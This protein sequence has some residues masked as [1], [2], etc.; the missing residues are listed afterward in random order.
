MPPAL[1]SMLQAPRTMLS[2]YLKI[3][4]RNLLRQKGFAFINITGLSIG[5]GCCMLIL[6]YTKDEVSYDAF[7]EKKDQLYRVTCRIQGKE[8]RNELF[9]IAAMIEGPSFKADIP[10]VESYTRVQER[11]FV[12]RKGKESFNE[13]ASWVDANFFQVFSFPLV[14]GDP[15]SVLKDIH[16]VVLTEEMAEKYFGTTRAIGKTL[17]LE[18]N[19]QFETFVV[20]GVA[21]RSPQNSSL[22]FGILLPFNYLVEKEYDD[23]WLWLSYPTYLVLHPGANVQAVS[24]KMTQIYNR[25]ARNQVAEASKHGFAA[26]FSWGIQPFLDMHLDPTVE[27]TPEVSNP[28]YSYILI[29][30]ALFVL[31]IA[32]INFVNLTVSQSLRRGREIG[33]RKVV[34]GQRRQLIFQFLGESFLLTFCAFLLAVLLSEAALP[35]FNELA[36][37][38]LSLSYL[39]DF[40]LVSSFILLFL[41]TGFAA[42]FYPALV[43]SGFDPMKTLY[44]RFQFSGKNYLSKGLVVLQFSLATFL[45]IT[46]LFVYS[47]FH[48]L[49][50]KNLGYNDKNLI[51]IRVGEDG[52]MPLMATFA[53]EFRKAPG[54]V[55]VAPTLGGDWGTISKANKVD[56]DISFRRIDETFFPTL[57]IPLAAGRNFSPAFP[58]DS[59]HSVIVNEAYIRKAG[60]KDSG[61]GHTVDYLNG[62]ER[63]LTIVGVVKD[64]HYGSLKEEIGPQLFTT[65]PHM[66]LGRFFVRVQPEKIPQALRSIEA[67][68][69]KL[70]PYHPFRYDFV[71]DLNHR[72][73]ESEAKWKQIISFAAVLTIFIS[74]IGLFGLVSLSIQRRTKEIGIRKVLGASAWQLS[75]LLSRNFLYLVLLAFVVAVPAAWYA[76]QR[77]LE[78]FAYKIDVDWKVFAAAAVLTTT[79]AVVTV[80]F[81][82][83]RMAL[84]NPANSLKTE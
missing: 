5:L 21:K 31:L 44:N 19:H 67:T 61:V 35:F 65:D 84:A 41:A 11:D 18:I 55:A 8:G 71:D 7:H 33:I 45:I 4:L 24:R 80:G 77:W 69:R 37:K 9:G 68:Y 57:E 54:V 30:I 59:T 13:K 76:T 82:T 27:H 79:I 14:S 25:K 12:I 42:G 66:P 6:L 2:N 50:T 43:L 60:W 64:Y 34:G 52:N 32:C 28:V 78:N 17:E 36:N 47:Q 72:N 62:R 83:F 49:T 70:V 63:N 51:S 29:C 48:F 40:Q 73:Y 26:T 39:F 56:I 22:K 10:E 1:C 15:K 38:Q 16:S 3:A 46:T 75:A 20:S 58:A 81:N 23:N 74:C 53:E